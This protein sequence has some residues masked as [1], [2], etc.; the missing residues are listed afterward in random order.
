MQT[1]FVCLYTNVRHQIVLYLLYLVNSKLFFKKAQKLVS[2]DLW[3][4]NCVT[5]NRNIQWHCIFESVWEI[6]WYKSE[7]SLQSTNVYIDTELTKFLMYLKLI[8]L[9]I[10]KRCID[11]FLVWF[12]WII[13]ELSVFLMWQKKKKKVVDEYL[14]KVIRSFV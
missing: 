11:L 1:V 8:F 6:E 13:L 10:C 14:V 2:L 7:K 3:T 12:E 9:R 5:W 4:Q